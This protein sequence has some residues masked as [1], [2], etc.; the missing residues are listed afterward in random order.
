[1]HH[2]VTLEAA[3][4]FCPSY[5]LEEIRQYN[6]NN[7]HEHGVIHDNC[8]RINSQALNY[9]AL[10]SLDTQVFTYN[11]SAL[12]ADDSNDHLA[13]V[14]CIKPRSFVKTFH[15]L[16]HSLSSWLLFTNTNRFKTQK[17]RAKFK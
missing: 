7:G 14:M 11:Q 13:A 1:M 6:F 2:C 10:F 3:N 16:H 8:L 5:T 15:S 4:F 17:E 12:S 9:N